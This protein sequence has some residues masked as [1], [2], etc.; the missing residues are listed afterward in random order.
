MDISKIS[1]KVFISVLL[2]LVLSFGSI[3]W[4]FA[5]D[6]ASGSSELEA[7]SITF[8]PLN[9][10]NQDVI[11]FDNTI[12]QLAVTLS[13]SSPYTAD[14][15]YV[16]LA[17]VISSGKVNTSDKSVFNEL[18]LIYNSLNFGSLSVADML[19]QL[20]VDFPSLVSTI[21]D[22]GNSA[23]T[24]YSMIEMICLSLG[25]FVTSSSADGV[26]GYLVSIKVCLDSIR[27]MFALSGTIGGLIDSIDSG[28]SN[29]YSPL[30]TVNTN[31]GNLIQLATTSNT[32][33]VN[34]KSALDSIHFDLSTTIHNDL[35][36]LITTTSNIDS[37]ISH[38]D[39]DLHDLKQWLNDTFYKSVSVESVYNIPY[40]FEYYAT[41][42][43][44][45]FPINYTPD[46]SGRFYSFVFDTSFLSENKIFD[47]IVVYPDSISVSVLRDFLSIYRWAFYYL[48]DSTTIK[49]TFT[50]YSYR[51]TLSS[52]DS[53][54]V[55]VHFDFSNLS[56]D[57]SSLYLAFAVN[58]DLVYFSFS[59][60]S[61]D[62]RQPYVYAVVTEDVN[63]IE[64]IDS[65]LHTMNETF[66]RFKEL[67]ASDDLVAA[68]EA[69][70]DYENSAIS[71]FTGSGSAAAST[72]DL[73]S[74]KDVSGALKSGLN[75]GGSVNNAMSVFDSQSNFW[76]WFSQEN[77]NLINNLSGSG[78]R[79]LLKS[80]SV[81]P[82]VLD[83][84]TDN[85]NEL[86]NSLGGEK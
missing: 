24:V 4:V 20:Y 32:N 84:Y 22:K 51:F 40:Y 1:L 13:A 36:S 37:T 85:W 19:Q 80:V 38:I 54:T 76:G 62:L 48:D 34:I 7:D 39:F 59:G 47:V 44:V 31:L 11:E 64:H 25:G 17:S 75:S 82:V 78:Q 56:L 8:A 50:D 63:L 6:D 58:P 57:S 9:T 5:D 41:N 45:S 15:I 60:S 28:V 3:C 66:D 33:Q 30:L 86:Q 52:L 79:R 2:C 61:P 46:P 74:A 69:Q 53:H 35:T 43:L 83:F 12:R 72:S 65:D 14:D 42:H 26:F 73:G 29:L 67:Y 27:D 71:E 68:K 81:E 70:Q 77:Y 23:N 18:V 55:K 49:S 16:L 10:L 21:G